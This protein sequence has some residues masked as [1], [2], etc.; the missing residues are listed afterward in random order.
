MVP[1]HHTV[2]LL[3]MRIV[4]WKKRGFMILLEKARE[5]LP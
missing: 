5:L 2:T 1:L 4:W 3:D